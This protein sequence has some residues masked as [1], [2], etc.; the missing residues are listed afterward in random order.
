VQTL[1]G[2]NN[3]KTTMIYTHLA[4]KPSIQSPVDRLPDFLP[5]LPFVES[6][7]RPSVRT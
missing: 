1:L 5:T 6:A 4:Q 7:S 2:H 3:V